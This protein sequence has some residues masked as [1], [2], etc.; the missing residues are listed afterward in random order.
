MEDA[1]TESPTKR[2]LDALA[3]PPQGYG[4][5]A[6]DFQLEF[7]RTTVGDEPYKGTD[8]YQFEDSPL[9][10]GR[11]QEEREMSSLFLKGRLC[12][13][14]AQ[15]GAGKTSILNA[16]VI[17]RIEETGLH[18]VRLTPQS[19]PLEAVRVASILQ[20][21]PPPECEAAA[22]AA[23]LEYAPELADSPIED[24]L[25][26][27]DDIH[28]EDPVRRNLLA[29]FEVKKL[30]LDPYRYRGGRTTPLFCKLLG[31]TMDVRSYWQHL[32]TFFCFDQIGQDIH[33]DLW[34]GA[35][36]HEIHTLLSSA[37]ARAAHREWLDELDLPE[38]GFVQ[39][40]RN[41]W[42]KWARK[43]S[44]FAL[45]LVID[46]FEQIFTLYTD[47]AEKAGQDAAE[48]LEK[49]DWRLRPSFF[50][51]LRRLLAPAQRSQEILPISVVLSMR[52]EY[53]G[54]LAS[55]PP[56]APARDT[57]QYR[58]DF[59]TVSDARRAIQLPAQAFGYDYEPQIYDEI[60]GAL[61]KENRFVE[62]AHIQIVCE[63]I[64]RL[65]GKD[66][67]RGGNVE[68]PKVSFD[69]FMEQ[70]GGT[71]SIQ[72][73]YFKEIL[74]DFDKS[75]QLEILDMLSDLLTQS[76]K[77]N[78]VEY[79]TLVGGALRDT[80]K[81]SRLIGV[82]QNNGIVRKEARMGSQFIEIAHEFLIA[83]LQ[84]EIVEHV[85]SAEQVFR[86]A[87]RTAAS[88]MGHSHDTHAP[89]LEKRAENLTSNAVL[90][91]IDNADRCAWDAEALDLLMHAALQ[92]GLQREDY[93]RLFTVYRDFTDAV[94]EPEPVPS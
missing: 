5:T 55:V 90:A 32:A 25:D 42:R 73:D 92:R 64:W 49:P 10:F 77:R 29:A 17:P 54:Q 33:D 58:L 18:T 26:R 79:K 51:E 71:V 8:S 72:R 76:S 21:I 15:S 83:P 53:V 36:L 67:K 41:F 56:L 85:N 59:L 35:P 86:Y 82:M 46:Q 34:K 84:K 30:W 52:D 28:S 88:A 81:R 43:Q 89:A 16:R 27:F 78:V 20:L 9:F 87:Q 94:A 24:V 31:G 62:P 61:K 12:L 39:F 70:T 14:H 2:R 23:M 1:A 74:Y 4:E 75:D 45:C 57:S 80:N 40:F 37:H 68:V 44:G 47:D 22:I 38:F 93:A 91:L 69:D 65:F 60:I 50:D 3:N 11:D 6:S 7:S 66:L 19:D 63:K 48:D 13:L